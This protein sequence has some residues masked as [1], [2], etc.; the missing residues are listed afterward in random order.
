[1]RLGALAARATA[2]APHVA[3]WAGL[4]VGAGLALG[5]PL[6]ALAAR[7]LGAWPGG[8]R[9][10]FRDDELLVEL[11][12]IVEASRGPL[13]ASA[14]AAA[15]A[16]ALLS[17]LPFAATLSALATRERLGTS[18]G[19]GLALVPPLTL[20]AGAALAL[21]AAV[22]AAVSFG[23]G[24]LAARFV[25]AEVS[26]RSQDLATAAAVLA[27][28]L[29]ALALGIV[30]DLVRV[31]LPDASGGLGR[32]TRAGLVTARRAPGRVAVAYVCRAGGGL[33]LA[34]VLARASLGLLRGGAPS[35]AGAALVGLASVLA[36]V[37]GRILW[38]ARALEL[39]REQ[40]REAAEPPH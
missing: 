13:V 7:V 39:V 3:L 12:R 31:A 4:R 23:G 34:L 16:T 36:L 33:A 15:V 6:S 22:F 30:H 19:R 26:P 32:A 37:A 24:A 29:S 10:L 28:G 18:L 35:V 1:M 27:A 20:L 21:E 14:T 2:L 40:R 8:D 38:L 11:A 25:S 9:R 17:V 5:A